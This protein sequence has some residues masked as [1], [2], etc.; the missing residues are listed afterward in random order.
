MDTAIAEETVT[1]EMP[2]A[3]TGYP[4]AIPNQQT[5]LVGSARVPNP[6]QVIKVLPQGVSFEIP[7]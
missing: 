3:P 7:G 4:A 5:G 2:T 6:N 1:V